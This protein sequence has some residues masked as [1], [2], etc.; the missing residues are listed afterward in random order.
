MK[1]NIITITLFLIAG[2][3]ASA[4][5]QNNIPT[6]KAKSNKVSVR[7][8]TQYYQNAWEIK[9]TPENDPDETGSEVAK[10]G[11]LFGFI[12]DIDSIGFFLKQG[13]SKSFRIILNEKD[14]TWARAKG[15]F[16][17]ANF[18][19]AYKKANDG[20]TLVEVPAA[21]E[22]INIIMAITPTGV[23]DS[24]LV[25]HDIVY[26]N[27]VQ[28]YFNAF[29]THKAV[30]VMDSLLKAN[31]YFNIKMD[32][33]CYDFVQGKLIKKT[34]YNRIAWGNENT[35][36]DYILLFQ[37]FAKQSKFA[38]FFKQNQPF[39]QGLIRA[40]RDTL[41]ITDMQN[42][43]KKNFPATHRNCIKIIFSP[44]VGGNQSATFFDNN[45]FKE[46]QAHVDFPSIWYNPK[47][48]QYSKKAFDVRRG[49]IVFTEL[50]HGYENPEFEDN[51]QNLA[52]F[53]KFPFKMDVFTT[54]GT[55]ASTYNNPLSCVEEYMNWALVSLRYIDFA[56]K[57]DWEALFKLRD[58]FMVKQRGFTKFAE[59][60][61]YLIN[62]YTTRP[63]GKVV[64]DLYPQIIKWFEDNNHF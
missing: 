27:K 50:N 48:S 43:L 41:G 8:G 57:E 16:P 30:A 36:I 31:Q 9:P 35:L 11:S 38:T 42:W 5:S 24:S 34:A 6:I 64:A 54:Q 25:E 4:Y 37:D 32:S 52:L 33:Y 44:L 1:S 21:Y 19:E 61:R 53:N 14:T 51:E 58:K 60:N 3:I 40:Y 62:L 63:Q 45:D 17:K 49:D 22:L 18:D 15:R 26:Y 23:R 56:P 10:E 39:Y 12:T 47:T 28:N 46:H 2:N 59:F 29:K 13:E 55:P 20:K 7:L